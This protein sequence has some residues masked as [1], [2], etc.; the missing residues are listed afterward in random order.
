MNL[1]ED[2]QDENNK[3]DFRFLTDKEFGG[4]TEGFWYKVGDILTMTQPGE[5]SQYV[6]D[7]IA[8]PGRIQRADDA[9]K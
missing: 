9:R 6:L 4:M 3:Y 5:T 1:I 2:A 7:N 8:L